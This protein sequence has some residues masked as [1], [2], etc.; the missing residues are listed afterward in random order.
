MT[1]GKV[2][3][4]SNSV[5][6]AV[7]NFNLPANTANRDALF[8]NTTPNAFVQ[9]KTVGQFGLDPTEMGVS[10]GSI[11]SFSVTDGGSGYFTVPSVTV[12]GNATANATVSATGRI[13]SVNIVTPGSGYISPATVTIAAPTVSFNAN[14]DVTVASDFIALPSNVLQ[15]GDRVTYLVAAGN[16]A[17]L[18]LAN[19]TAYF[20][21]SANTTGIKLSLAPSGAAIDLTAKGLTESGHSLVGQT[22]KANSSVSGL[23]NKGA[24]AGWVIR[25]EGSGGRAGRVTYETL[26]A[27][28]SMTGDAEDVVAKD[29]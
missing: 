7:T 21:S 8:G 14:T 24:H 5:S 20:V 27:M 10:N 22:A 26:V 25:T 1:W 29:T 15:N 23:K 28:G 12:S 13:S 4:T 2:D 18:P 6:H 3:N 19:N 11:V 16:T 9:G 17:L